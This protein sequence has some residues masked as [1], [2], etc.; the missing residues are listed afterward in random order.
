M[1]ILVTGASG[2]L[3][4]RLA[5]YLAE[6]G[7]DIIAVVRNL[8]SDSSRWCQKLVEVIVGDIRAQSTVD[9]I[10][11]LRPDAIVH[12]VSL[13][14]KKSEVDPLEAQATNVTPVWEILNTLA[15]RGLD[16]FVY[17][18]TQQV[19]G[20]VG[21][22]RVTEQTAVAPTNVYGLT[23]LLS[24]EICNLYSR[25]TETR[26]ISLRISNGF[27]APVFRSCNCW[28]L[29]INDFCN[30]AL[31][32]GKIRL[33]S[34]GTP[35]RDFVHVRD[36]CRAVET[37]VSAPREQIQYSCYNIGSGRT[38]TILELAVLTR[39]VCEE[40]LKRPISIVMPD[41]RVW[42]DAAG[43][44]QIPRFSYDVSRLRAIGIESSVTL[45]QGI[46]EVLSFLQNSRAE[47]SFAESGT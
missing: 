30:M 1:R 10:A 31:R 20:R 5:G 8:P 19:Y 42:T 4:G 23:H 15:A 35:Q 7:H 14:H 27:G 38:Y 26:C 16:R 25:R 47:N 28:W 9:K 17:F 21:P 24:E 34:D 11:A 2:Y 45:E 37:L 41:N 46:A 3:G 32:D 13:D 29:V 36:I 44:E 40:I 39:S 12:T 43:H 6:N 18:S 33:S 22:N